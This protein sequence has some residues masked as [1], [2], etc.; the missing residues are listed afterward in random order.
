MIKLSIIIPVYNCEKYLN[1]CLD[2]LVRELNDN[3]EIILVDDGSTDESCD[4]C[5]RYS[6]IYPMIKVLHQKNQGVSAARN[7]GLDN[8][9]G[10]FIMFVDSDDVID[11]GAITKLMRILDEKFDCIASGIRYWYEYN[12]K[13]ENYLLKNVTFQYRDNI[14][15]YYAMLNENRFF[16]AIY[17]KIY[18]RQII[19]ENHI[20]FPLEFSIWE[21]SAFVYSYLSYCET[22]KCV[23]YTFYNY[24]QTL[25]ES[26]VK[27]MHKNS[28]EALL[29]RHE[30]SKYL[31]E[32]LDTIHVKSYYDTLNYW[33]TV[34]LLRQCYSFN[35]QITYEYIKKICED[36]NVIEILKNS[37]GKNLSR[38]NRIFY[39]LLRHSYYK[40]FY[41]LVII[42]KK[43]RSKY[44]R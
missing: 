38:V 32:Y 39:E 43:I 2:P 37:S 11:D 17:S 42:A 3:I 6:S 23:D 22:I 34:S 40:L 35:I 4:I 8:A 41:I 5:D 1:D 29:Y 26:L 28:I 24:R 15:E 33:F 10:E 16:S 19:E 21:D 12:G 20:R 44:K 7:I 9:T 31:I 25:G 18:K 13:V 30:C 14:N 36:E 27:K